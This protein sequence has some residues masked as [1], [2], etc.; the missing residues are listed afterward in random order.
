MA[1]DL[2]PAGDSLVLP[3]GKAVISR[4]L[5]SLTHFNP[6]GGYDVPLSTSSINSGLASISSPV[7]FA[8]AMYQ[9]GQRRVFMRKIN[10][11]NFSLARR[12]TPRD[13]NR[14]IALTLV[15]EHQPIS[16][17]DLARRMNTTR[18]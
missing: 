2:R 13:I 18:G 11:Q 8:R 10:P 15:R 4:L 6:T 14:R 9:T 5:F 12:S 3:P 1:V 17:A 16:R 7:N